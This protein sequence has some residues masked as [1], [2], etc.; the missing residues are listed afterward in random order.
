MPLFG[1][2]VLITQT[3]LLTPHSNTEEWTERTLNTYNAR[4]YCSP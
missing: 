1:G 3:G 2:L 4:L